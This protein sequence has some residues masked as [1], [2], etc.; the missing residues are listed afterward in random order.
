MSYRAYMFSGLQMRA[1][2]SRRPTNHCGI[3]I[4]NYVKNGHQSIVFPE[5]IVSLCSTKPTY[6]V[7]SDTINSQQVRYLIQNTIHQVLL[8]KIW[9]HL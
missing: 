6:G 7:G 5:K 8:C 9:I 4:A 2:N 3:I 1:R